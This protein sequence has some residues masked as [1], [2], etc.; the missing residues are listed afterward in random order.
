MERGRWCGAGILVPISGAAVS[1]GVL[2]LPEGF[3]AAEPTPKTSTRVFGAL[4]VVVEKGK[5]VFQ[6]QNRARMV[7]HRCPNGRGGCVPRPSQDLSGDV[8]GG[9]DEQ[10][11][12]LLGMLL[13]TPKPQRTAP[14]PHV[15][16][17]RGDKAPALPYVPS[18]SPPNHQTP[19]TFSVSPFR[20]GSSSFSVAWK[21]YRATDSIPLAAVGCKRGPPGAAWGSLPHGTGLWGTG[22]AHGA[23]GGQETALMSAPHRG[24]TASTTRDAACPRARLPRCATQRCCPDVEGPARAVY[25][26]LRDFGRKSDGDGPGA[27]VKDVGEACESGWGRL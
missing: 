11:P 23:A 18:P 19:G 12:P 1:G 24:E 9:T 27:W 25:W 5:N 3:L 10:Y 17:Q 7:C 2:R 26:H 6:P 13:C 4:D 14:S 22:Q 21:L 20:K 8:P 16:P 15:K